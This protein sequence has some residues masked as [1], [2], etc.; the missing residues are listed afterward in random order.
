MFRPLEPNTA[1]EI[2]F[3]FDNQTITAS[4]G[5]TI[6]AALLAS[7]HRAFRETPVSGQARG[8]FCM[9]GACFDCLVRIDGESVQACM[10]P[11]QAGLQVSRVL[12]A[13]NKIEAAP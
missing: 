10:V 8:P 3:M 4:A 11:V 5:M 13:E 1:S 6:A 12:R 2:T 7:G 9:M